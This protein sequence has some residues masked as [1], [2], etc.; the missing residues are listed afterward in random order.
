MRTS[1]RVLGQASSYQQPGMTVGAGMVGGTTGG[2]GMTG[3]GGTTGG[4][5]MGGAEVAAGA[6]EPPL[7]PLALDVT[8]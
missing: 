3:G 1:R 7:E 5:G 4:A 8:L 6:A 2:G